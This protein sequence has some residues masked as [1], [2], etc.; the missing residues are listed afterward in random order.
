MHLQS[1][2]S[3]SGANLQVCLLVLALSCSPCLQQV[4]CPP[5]YGGGRVPRSKKGFSRVNVGEDCAKDHAK[6]SDLQ[7][8]E[9]FI[10]Y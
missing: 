8:K 10:I 4:A 5:P 1:A 7:D 9:A 6:D 2:G 3:S